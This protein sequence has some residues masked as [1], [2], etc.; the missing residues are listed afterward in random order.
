MKTIT[1]AG[2]TVVPALLTLEGLGFTV[3]VERVAGRE[4][5]RAVRDDETFSGED[6]VTVL[7]L[8]KLVEARGWTWRAGDVDLERV[9]RQYRLG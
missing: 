6:P 4:V 8:V 2:N 7:G 5:F 1:T 9:R 3:S